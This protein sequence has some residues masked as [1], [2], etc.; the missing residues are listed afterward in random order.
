MPV[1]RRPAHAAAAGDPIPFSHGGRT[2]LFYLSSPPGTTDYPERVRTS[3]EHVASDDLTRWEQLPTALGPGPDGTVDAGGVWTGSVVEHEG[4]FHLFY[5]GHDPGSDHPQ[6]ICLATSTDLVTFR[7]HDANPLLLPVPGYEPVDWRDPYVFF[8]ADEGRWWMLI[9]ARRAHGPQWRRGV[10]VL[11]TSDDLLH[12]SVEPE[13]LYDPGTTYC[14]ECPELW[15]LDGRWYLVFSR[16]SEDVGTVYRVADSPR[17]PFRTPERDALGGRRWYAAKSAP[18]PGG[19]LFFGWVHDRVGDGSNERWLWGGDFAAPRRVEADA[20]GSLRV[21]PVVDAWGPSEAVGSFEGPLGAPGRTASAVVV[22]ELPAEAVIDARV[23]QVEAATAGLDLVGSDGAG[24][25][26]TFDPRARRL[27]LTQEPQPLDDF[28]ADLTGRPGDYREVDGPVLAR[29]DLPPGEAAVSLRVLLDGELLEVYAD[30]A[31]AL[32][33]RAPRRRVL[34]LEAFVTDGTA[35]VE[36]RV[37]RLV[38]GTERS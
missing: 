36:V 12:W 35:A 33:W 34:R 14:P 26:V 30:D 15:P 7:R 5:T 21:L 27:C 18:A 31:V 6:T 1:F 24:L 29:A 20:N 22:D 8:N 32:T 13:P 37:G 3:W 9:A 2:H 28:W 38:H 17:G 4:V 23:D 16:F 25:R 10:I 19:R 11:A